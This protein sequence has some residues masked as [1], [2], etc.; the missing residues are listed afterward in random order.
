MTKSIKSGVK[1]TFLGALAVTV[2]AGA[3]MAGCGS[4][5]KS[6]TPQEPPEKR[7]L[8]PRLILGQNLVW[9]GFV[10]SD[11]GYMGGFDEIF[12]MYEGEVGFAFKSDSTLTL[13]ANV[14]GMMWVPIFT[15]RWYTRND[16]L[17][18]Y[19]ISSEMGIVNNIP[20]QIATYTVSG[21]NLTV[22]MAGESVP[23]T[24]K[25]ITAGPDVEYDAGLVNT[26]WMSEDGVMWSF[27]SIELLPGV[28]INFASHNDM[29]SELE[30]EEFSWYT[31]NGKL[32][33]ENFE[34]SDDV[35]Q[36]DYHISGDVLTLD[37]VEF[38]QIDIDD[39]GDFEFQS[40]AKKSLYQKLAKK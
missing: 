15:A 23:F 38:T 7:E 18:A 37:G 5:N 30:G 36:L 19:D 39:D 27:I 17:I 35:R 40:K 11:Y 10:G 9:A 31:K 25:D 3:L 8:D 12:E 16:T 4:D 20:N 22:V 28:F 13:S 1:R 34:D 33:L 29:H 14:S 26:A 6:V 32:Y 2:L 21:A 24:Q